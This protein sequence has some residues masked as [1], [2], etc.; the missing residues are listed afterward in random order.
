MKGNNQANLGMIVYGDP[1]RSV[2]SSALLDNLQRRVSCT[3]PDDLDGLRLLLIQ[4]GQMEQAAFDFWPDP[5]RS[6]S[7]LLANLLSFTDAAAGAFFAAWLKASPSAVRASIPGWDCLRRRVNV[8][9]E[10]WPGEDPVLTVK[11]PEGFEF[12]ALYPEQYC[13]AALRWC[14]ERQGAATKRGMVVGIRSIGT[15]LSALI[16]VVLESAGWQVERVT[17]RPTGHPFARRVELKAHRVGAT[18]AFAIVADEGPGL[19]GSSMAA[20]AQALAEVG[21]SDLSFFPGHGDDPGTAGS[22]EIRRWWANTPRHL[23]P[24]GELRWEGRSLTDLLVEKSGEFPS[25]S[26]V[27]HA[28]DKAEAGLQI[29]LPDLSAGRWRLHAFER[30]AD[31]PTTCLALERMKFLAGENTEQPVLW[32]FTGLGSD[33]GSGRVSIEEAL[34]RLTQLSRQNLVPKPLG[35]AHGFLAMEWV[36]GHRLDRARSRDRGVLEHL[37][38]YITQAA[39]PPQTNQEAAAAV[40]RLASML[41]HNSREAFG[42]PVV[43]RTQPWI[44]AACSESP[45]LTYG[46]GRMAPWEW[47]QTSSGSLVKTD[48]FGHD[49]DHTIVGRQ[50]VLWDVAGAV[51]EWELDR[52]GELKLCRCL[53][54]HGIVT[55][56]KVLHFYK[57][58][59]AAFRLGMVSLEAGYRGSVEEERRVSCARDFYARSL[60]ALL[61]PD[62]ENVELMN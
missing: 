14:E 48:C 37:G 41:V 4:A 56:P 58:C 3:R 27:N 26:R 6:I 5:G 31:W 23:V 60:S 49:V 2:R 57:M 42:Q 51:V 16:K 8:L 1:Q 36:R 30:K 45:G 21:Y 38:A 35:S 20:A 12:Y 34:G 40:G 15:T 54:S 53:E 18:S 25:A 28:A 52:A 33:L 39:R 11:I 62:H 32:R 43:E 9:E 7:V 13:A 46:D 19:S 22:A 47:V 10:V 29:P 55:P 61:M 17:V 50:S 59:Y 24:L 44:D